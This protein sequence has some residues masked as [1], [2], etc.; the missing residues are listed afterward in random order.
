MNTKV[1]NVRGLGAILASAM[2]AAALS[3]HVQ[4]AELPP[5]IAA[6]GRLTIGV[7]CSYPPAGYVGLNGQPAGYEIA[8]AKLVAEAAFPGRDALV[9]QC[10]SDANRIPFLQSGKVDL[11]IAALAWTPVRAAEIDFSDPIWISN[12]QLI[13]PRDSTIDSYDDVVGKTVVTTAGNIYQPWLERCQP[14]VTIVTAQ[15]PS[16]ASTMLVQGRADA[17]AYIDV[18]A[19]NFTQK[20]GQFKLVGRLAS[21]AVQGIGMKKGNQA[22]ADWLN[23]VLGILREKD[24]FF[25]AFNE[26]VK[27]EAFAAK[28]RDLV[29]G[30]GH[31]IEYRVVTDAPCVD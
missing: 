11:I 1:Q 23:P 30:P 12:L 31:L 4:A 2:A 20:N 27:D 22:M 28:Y 15:S 9:T 25:T 14:G 7:N 10:V 6:T 17:M 18:Y 13:V 5:E 8:I 24:A 3:G 16:D 29:P 26:E 21:S 19:F